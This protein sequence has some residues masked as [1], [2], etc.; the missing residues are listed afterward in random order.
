MSKELTN[1]FRSV[2]EKWNQFEQ[3]LDYSN[4]DFISMIT[5]LEIF[6]LSRH[7]FFFFF[8]IYF[9]NF[10]SIRSISITVCTR[11]YLEC[12]TQNIL[13]TNLLLIFPSHKFISNDFLADSVGLTFCFDEKHVQ[14]WSKCSSLEKCYTEWRTMSREI[15]RRWL[16]L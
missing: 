14:N 3:N 8:E 7:D 4:F 5:V 11:H 12:E 15:L 1:N 6:M 16:K 9:A 10:S 13:W 2:I